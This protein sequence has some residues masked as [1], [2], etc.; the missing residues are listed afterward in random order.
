MSKWYEVGVGLGHGYGVMAESAEE[1]KELV[2][3]A[4][5]K[6]NVDVVN[7]AKLWKKEDLI[8]KEISE[9]KVYHIIPAE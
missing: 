2:W 3:E 1:A 6:D 9:Q 7:N 8:V 5:F 4:A